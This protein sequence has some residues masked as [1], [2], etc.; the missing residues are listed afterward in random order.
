MNRHDIQ[1]D[2]SNRFRHYLAAG[3]VI[4][5]LLCFFSLT[6]FDSAHAP[7]AKK[8]PV[9]PTEVVP[10]QKRLNSA[11]GAKGGGSPKLAGEVA[12]KFDPA[13]YK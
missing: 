1:P 3:T 5:L 12:S 4:C 11:N 13:K 10:P 9:L 8:E 6:D 7:A 2:K